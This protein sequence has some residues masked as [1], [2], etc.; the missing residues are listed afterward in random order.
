MESPDALSCTVIVVTWNAAGELRDCLASL[1]PQAAASAQREI[2]VVDNG[3]EDDTVRMLSTEFPTVTIIESGSNL[4]FAAAVNL[5]IAAA[6][7]G[8]VVLLNN[9]ATA[10]AGFLDSLVVSLHAHPDT[11]AVTARLILAN[12]YER[13]DRGGLVDS[14]GRRWARDSNGAELINSTGGEMTRSGNGRDRDWLV[15]LNEHERTAGGVLGFSGGAVALRVAALDEVGGFDDRYFMYYEDSDLSWRLRRA[16]WQIRYEP[17]AIARHQHAA[18][19]GTESDFFL[20]HN[21]RNRVLFAIKNLPAGLALLAI[22]RSIA[23]LPRHALRAPQGSVRRDARAL[24]SAAALA[25]AF[26][27]SRRLQQRTATVSRRTLAQSL[28]RD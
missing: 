6:R 10:D 16:G 11:A 12:R 27:R 24:R 3:S 19:S 14:A 17:E 9:D 28:L 23:A 15:P 20:F 2:I 4:G 1:V 21:Q 8:T 26:L 25:P 5:G 18:S 7:H 22:A 13:T